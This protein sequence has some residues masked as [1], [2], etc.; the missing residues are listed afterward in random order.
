MDEF[1]L[2]IKIPKERIAVLIGTKGDV[3]KRIEH[4]TNSKITIDSDE[5]DVFIKGSDGLDIFTAREII[6]AI[7]R[8]FNPEVAMDLLKQDHSLEILDLKGLKTKNSMLRI[9]GRV[10]GDEG[11]AR[12]NLERLT[13]TKISV[14][15]KTIAIIGRVEHVQL[16]K[17]A[18][19]S[20]IKGSPHASVYK[21]LERKR[22]DLK[23]GEFEEL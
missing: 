13:E 18:V 19:E 23:R 22:K 3:K 5:G 21:W 9:K 8:G 20:L 4:E 15:G 1:I 16:C 14:Y 11:R 10:I 7:A 6:K 17:S 2:G 12:K